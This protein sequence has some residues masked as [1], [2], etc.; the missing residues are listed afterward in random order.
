M[1]T[2]VTGYF[3]SGKTEFCLNLAMQT[4]GIIADLDTVNPYFRSREAGGGRQ[5][6]A[7]TVIS[8][9]F[10]GNTGQDLPAVSLA[11]LSR[12]RAGENVIIDLGGGITGLRLLAPCYDAIRTVP[13]QFLCVFNLFRPETDSAKKMCAYVDS[14]NDAAQLPIT[15]LVNNGHMLH[16]TTASHVLAT[17]DA[18]LTT[19]L[20]IRYT[21]LHS[22][23]H[24]E[25]G[26]MLK[27]D[28]V[29]TFDK[30]QIRESWLLGDGSRR[31]PSPGS[32]SAQG[33]ELC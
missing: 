25:I 15:G 14:I 5:D 8:D 9:H 31:E 10:G 30:L 18:A 23:I 7:P 21:M 6:V 32:V 2:I 3:G 1:T 28:K 16:H 17:Q 24:A 20:P 27:S 12:V 22:A 11:F 13:H 4:G 19:G 26:Y 29:I 33:D